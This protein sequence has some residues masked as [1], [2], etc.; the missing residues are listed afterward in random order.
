MMVWP[1]ILLAPLVTLLNLSLTYALV[2]PSCASQTRWM[3]HGVSM[4]SFAVTVLS[5]LA[6]LRALR[7]ESQERSEDA[8][9]APMRLHFLAQL[10]VL[11]GALSALVIL[12]QWVPSWVLPP[13][14]AG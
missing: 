12:A 11:L 5:A 6:G 7:M 4:V 3:L 8:G 14:S 1:G 2:L 10:A 13:C 9:T